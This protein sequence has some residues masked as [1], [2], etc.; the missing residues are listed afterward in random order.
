MKLGIMQPYFFPYIGYWQLLNAVDTYVVYDDVNYINRGWV[1]RNRILINQ[2]PQYFNV[3]LSGASQ[4]KKINEIEVISDPKYIKKVLRTLEQSYG[5]APYFDD[6]M[7]LLIKILNNPQNNLALFLFDQI[8]M[9]STYLGIDTKLVLSSSLKKN[10][11]LR[12]EDKI[13][14]ICLNLG[15]DAYYNAIGGKELYSKEKFAKN[16]IALHFLETNEIVYKQFGETF[17]KNLS[18]I[19][20]MMF[21]SREQVRELLE[22]FHI[23]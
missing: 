15:A 12:G 6:V 5:K 18:I 13:L 20:V 10:V 11:I 22:D 14:D 17:H 16:G 7:P 8:A 3:M 2:S 1:N 23:V 4:N 9:I 19:D 21:N